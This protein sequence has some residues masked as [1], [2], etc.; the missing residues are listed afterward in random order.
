[1]HIQSDQPIV[2][3]AMQTIVSIVRRGGGIIHPDLSVLQIGERLHIRCAAKPDGAPLLVIP[4]EL[5]VPVTQFDWHGDGGVLSYTGDET[6]LTGTQNELLEAMLAI[7][8]AT[9]KVSAVAERMPA[10]LLPSDPDL[11]AWLM[12]SR[13]SFSLPEGSSARQF[14][15]TRLHYKNATENE[16]GRIGFIMPLIDLL[17]H[18]PYGPEYERTDSGAWR[19]PLVKPNPRSDECFVRYSKSDC[20]SLAIWH[21]YFEPNTRYLASVDCR[22]VHAE[23]GDI[24]IKGTNAKYRKI[25]A[26]CVL[27]GEPILTLQDLVLDKEQLQTLRTL[28]GL[29]VRSKRRDLAQPEAEVVAA[30]LIQLLV[31]ANI[32]KYAELQELCRVD[33]GHFPLRP[34]FGQVAEHQL[35]LLSAMRAA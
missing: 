3:Q 31:E 11:L 35:A 25:N 8:N 32:R 7:Y 18:H 1:M 29:A 5:F 33:A 6:S 27:P 17:N 30:E 13:A 16:D 26:P 34:L 9:G 2:L 22:L 20:L 14:I 21:A 28:L 10:R 24:R 4:D 23:L 19:I 15:E 12:T